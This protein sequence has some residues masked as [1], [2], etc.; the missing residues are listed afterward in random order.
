[1]LQVNLLKSGLKNL[2]E[3]QIF[4]DLV[5]IDN[6]WY[7]LSLEKGI[8]RLF[9]RGFLTKE[10]IKRFMSINNIKGMCYIPIMGKK[11]KSYD[12]KFYTG[13]THKLIR[14]DKRHYLYPSDKID[15]QDKKSFRTKSRRWKRDY[16]I[17]PTNLTDF[18]IKS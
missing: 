14:K 17:L 12:L 7:I 13:N 1:M 3:V 5:I 15:N 8:P 6:H 11:A 2:K 10:D 18:K 16:G 9:S 4:N